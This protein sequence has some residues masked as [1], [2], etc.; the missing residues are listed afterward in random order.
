[1]EYGTTFKACRN[2]GRNGKVRWYVYVPARYSATGHPRKAYYPTR[3]AAEEA[4]RNW[5]QAVRSHGEGAALLN[6]ETTREV[7]SLLIKLAPYGV[8]LEEVVNDWLALQEA[9]KAPTAAE[10]AAKYLKSKEGS[11]RYL[12][13]VNKYLELFL[14]SFGALPLDDIGAADFAE[15]LEAVTPTPTQYNHLLRTLKPFFTYAVRMELATKSPARSVVQKKVKGGA[16]CVLTVAQARELVTCAAYMRGCFIPV[17]LL[18]FTGI[19]PAELA[20]LR[21]SNIKLDKGLLYITE[22]ISKTSSVRLVTIEPL[23]LSFLRA[24]PNSCKRGDV[25]PPNWDER[26]TRIRAAAGVKGLQDVCRHSYASYWLAAHNG[27]MGGLLQN[28]GHTTQQTTLKHYRA[29]VT[30]EDAAAFWAIDPAQYYNP[31]N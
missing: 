18:L 20:R 7:N 15:W 9:A 19:R 22:D 29:A 5:R 14:A 24:L 2:T 4:G 16:P 12:K 3:R 28:M 21:W 23:L 1:M 13:Q 17:C 25:A 6:V 27:D 26:W 31:N 8:S 11:P 10:V 30:A